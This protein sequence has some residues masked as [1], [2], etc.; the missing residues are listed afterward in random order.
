M[1]R[2]CARVRKGSMSHRSHHGCHPSWLFMQRIRAWRRSRATPEPP[3]INDGTPPTAANHQR[4][5]TC[6]WSCRS[7]ER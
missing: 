5:R 4:S 2:A 3:L 7:V 6:Y 1:S